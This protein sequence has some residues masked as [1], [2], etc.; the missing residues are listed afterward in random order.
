MLIRGNFA[1]IADEKTQ[2][3]PFTDPVNPEAIDGYEG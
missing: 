3:G 1:V 2:R